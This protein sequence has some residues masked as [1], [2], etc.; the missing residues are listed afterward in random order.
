V[1]VIH[2]K[3]WLFLTKGKQL[4]A[5]AKIV[6]VYDVSIVVVLIDTPPFQLPTDR[7]IPSLICRDDGIVGAVQ[8]W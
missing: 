7:Q 5:I 1:S 3:S 6:L 2:Q 8:K 4:F